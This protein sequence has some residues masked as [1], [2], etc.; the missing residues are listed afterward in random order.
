MHFTSSSMEYP[1]LV[2]LI[3]DDDNIQFIIDFNIL[4]QISLNHL[5]PFLSSNETQTNEQNGNSQFELK[6]WRNPFNL[7]RG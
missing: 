5:S 4:E 1:S 7:F 2:S 6:V 3:F